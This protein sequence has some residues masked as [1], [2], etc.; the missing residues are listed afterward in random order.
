VCFRR[1]CQHHYLR[2]FTFASRGGGCLALLLEYVF[3]YSCGRASTINTQFGVD[4]DKESINLVV[5]C[6]VGSADNEQRSRTPIED[7][8]R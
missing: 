7:T 4:T 8:G 6:F 2:K 3:C 5:F 1:D